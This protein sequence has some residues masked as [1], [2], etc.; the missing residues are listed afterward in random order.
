MDYNNY[1]NAA[2][3]GVGVPYD[4]ITWYNIEGQPFGLASRFN[5]IVFNDANNIIDVEGPMVIGGSFNSP[6]GLS[7]GF[8]R[9][10]RNQIGYS[11][12]LVRFLAGG[13]VTMSGPLVV[14]GH[15]VVGGGF[16]TA[17]GSTYLIGKDGTADQSRELEYLYQAAGGSPYW[18]VS[19]KGDHYI[20]P[21]YDVPRFIPTYRIGANLP[22]FFQNARENMEYY[23]DC[24]ESL[25]VNGTVVDNNYELILRGNDPRQNVFLVDVRP[26][27]LL[28]KGLRAEVPSGSLVIVR[29]R[30]GSNAHLQ[31]GVYGEERRAGQTLYVFE[32][33]ANIHMEKSSDIWGSILAPQA[34]FHAHP[35][36]GH[37]SG[38]VALRAFAVNA[39]SGFEFHY[40]PFVGGLVCAEAAPPVTPPVPPVTPPAPPVTP[41][42]TPPPAPPVME[43]PECPICPEPVPCP[44]CP[45]PE[46][47]PACPEP[48]PCPAC[49][50]CPEPEPC[51]VCPTCP[52]PE[53]CPAC[54]TCP[55]PEPCPTCPECPACPEPTTEYVA[56]PVPIPVP[57]AAEPVACPA[58]PE[59]P[60]CP[61]CLITPGVI[62][63]CI[64]GCNCCRTHKWEVKLY[65][66]CNDMKTL[67]YCEKITGY[68]CFEFHVPYEGCYVLIVC[69]AGNYKMTGKCKPI[70]T[71]K[72][73]GVTN[74][75]ME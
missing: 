55:E 17:K 19:D 32:D 18:T 72:N 3:T 37:V 66:L 9:D 69:P 28:T 61:E 73:I 47:C 10:S 50:T 56:F 54:P 7:V 13:N 6:R 44:I 14:I 25:E 30:T 51:P 20:V 21:S 42:V 26:N 35:T 46:P 74:F 64:W 57:I 15:V 4:D 22:L 68:G 16:R 11:P 59:C 36:G 8:E 71:L 34:M 60:E 75:M 62:I 5:V 45:E 12:D 2:V 65:K 1:G 41:P 48:V 52:E 24:I 31:Y 67:L 39:N 38:N 70:V 58:C 49:P 29:L 40:Y 53:P 27:G 33:A 23:M 63:G 43:C